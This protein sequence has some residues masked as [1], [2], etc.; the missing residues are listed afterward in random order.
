MKKVFTLMISLVLFLSVAIAPVWA[1]GD[2]NHG[3][4]GQGTTDQ[5]DTG[6]DDASPGDDAQGNQA[7]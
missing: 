6:S 7:P 5:G 3:D 1:G 2:K 4:V